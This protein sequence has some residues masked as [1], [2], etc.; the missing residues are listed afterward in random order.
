MFSPSPYC[1]SYCWTLLFP[2]IITFLCATRASSTIVKMDEGE[3]LSRSDEY[4]VGINFTIMRQGFEMLHTLITKTP[5][6]RPMSCCTATQNPVVRWA[7]SAQG[8]ESTIAVLLSHVVRISSIEAQRGNKPPS[9][10]YPALKYSSL[11]VMKMTRTLLGF[12]NPAIQVHTLSMVC[13]HI[14]KNQDRVILPQALDFLRP[15]IMEMCKNT[16]QYHDGVTALDDMVTMQKIVEV[17]DIFLTDLHYAFGDSASPLP[18]EAE[19][20]MCCTEIYSSVFAIIRLQRLWISRCQT[21]VEE[22][23]MQDEKVLGYY[24]GIV[25]WIDGCLDKLQSF[26]SSLSSLIN[27]WQTSEEP[28]PDLHRLFLMQMTL[29]EAFQA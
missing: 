11:D 25:K 3:Y 22:E 9:E 19:E 21:A 10:V 6:I 13:E 8:L 5:A 2:H 16:G 26:D 17:L 27:F 12:Y 1:S 20:F 18:E 23:V 15:I 24:N 4:L 7:H 14:K 29:Q 28:P